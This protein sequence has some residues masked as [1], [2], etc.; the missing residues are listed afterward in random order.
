MAFE[1]WN[2][3]ATL[4]SYESAKEPVLI[5]DC[6]IAAY[7]YYSPRARVKIERVKAV[8]DAAGVKYKEGV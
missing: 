1:D 6:V 8:L 3:R 4:E 5:K 7:G 2:T